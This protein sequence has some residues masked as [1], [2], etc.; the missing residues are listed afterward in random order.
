MI[1]MTNFPDFLLEKMILK[2]AVYI[3]EKYNFIFI[4]IT[5]VITDIILKV[6]PGITI[7]IDDVVKCKGRI[8]GEHKVVKYGDKL[9][10]A[11]EK[12]P[13]IEP[14]KKYKIK[15]TF[16]TINEFSMEFEREVLLK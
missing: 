7:L 3:S 2:D 5:N 6:Y 10:V 11:F 4:E 16:N 8:H 14:F 13:Y 9:T 15:L 1:I 12:P